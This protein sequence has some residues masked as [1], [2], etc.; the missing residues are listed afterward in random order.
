ML[1]EALQRRSNDT[2]AMSCPYQRSTHTLTVLNIAAAPDDAAIQAFYSALSRRSTL[3][4]DAGSSCWIAAGSTLAHAAL[5]H[6]DLGV[7]PP[8]QAVPAGLQGRPLGAVFGRW[9][10]MR[11]DG[12]REAEKRAV[13]RA[14]ESLDSTAVRQVARRQADLAL[15]LS[16]SHWQWASTPCT[17]AELLG[18][19]LPQ[20]SDQQALLEKLAALALAL[21]PQADST[22]LAQG[23]HAVAALLTMLANATQGLLAHALQAQAQGLGLAETPE[24]WRAQA[25][26]LLWQ[27]Y[28]AGAG[29]LGQA[30]LAATQ[31]RDAALSDLAGCADLLLAVARRPGV[32][33]HTRRWAMRDCVLAGQALSAGEALL[34][35]LAHGA[36]PQAEP[37]SF[38][39]GR[40]RCPGIAL[41]LTAAAE[42][43]LRAIRQGA[44]KRPQC[45]GFQA[46]ANARIPILS[47][48]TFRS[49]QA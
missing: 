30:L 22:A 46:L 14:L 9:L 33:H 12:P 19:S 27:G 6:P 28:E 11:E 38:G 40:H 32:I 31:S 2:D 34:V 1:N 47:N 21:R 44:S 8:G 41:S 26:A 15:G 3:Q 18:I 35:I 20:A 45:L 7:R 48:A 25:L 17:V 36:V 49:E 24:W 29:L 37:L 43:L 13:E 23:D 42:A 10:R 16:W 39:I 4:F 5:Q